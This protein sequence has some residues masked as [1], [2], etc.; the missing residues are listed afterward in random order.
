MIEYEY[1]RRLRLAMSMP[2]QGMLKSKQLIWKMN[3]EDSHRAFC[4]YP[5][6]YIATSMF[7]PTEIIAA[8]DYPFI[9]YEPLAVSIGMMNFNK[10]LIERS[11]RRFAGMQLCSPIEVML[12]MIEEEM[13]PPPGAIVLSSYMCDDA[14]KMYELIARR[15][16]C[17]TF[18]L[19][20]PFNTNDTSMRYI[21]EQ[22]KSFVDF[23]EEYTGKRMDPCSLKKAINSSNQAN[24]LRYKILEMRAKHQVTE[25]SDVFPLYPLF[26][27]FGRIETLEILEA[28]HTEIYDI[29]QNGQPFKPKYRIMWI[30]MIP[31]LHNKLMKGIERTYNAG[32]AIEENSLFS[33]W[34]PIN[35]DNPYEDLAKKCTAYHPMG[36][37][38]RRIEAVNKFHDMFNVDGVIHFSHQGCRAYNGGVPFIAQEMKRRSIPFVELNGDIIDHRHFNEG[39][40]SLRLEAF[41]EIIE[42]RRNVL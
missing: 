36:N 35:P 11:E 42:G 9:P 18:F 2:A 17:Q 20:I 30:G 38:K 28:L 41:F 27:K 15:Y 22:L 26:T 40:L 8:M 19:D 12:G 31:L 24:S 33:L 6:R 5:G 25:V 32:I 39:P 34:S 21:E 4:E 13:I 37:I 7:L 14:Q 23:L 1:V 10:G 3:Y 16:N 29:I